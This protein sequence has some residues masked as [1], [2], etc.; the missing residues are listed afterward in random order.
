MHGNDLLTRRSLLL[1]AA[2]AGLTACSDS[3]SGA[4]SSATSAPPTSSAPTTAEPVDCAPPAAGPRAPLWQTALSRGLV[5]GSSAATWQIS[6]AEYRKLFQREAAILFTEDDLLWYRLRPSPGADL[7]FSFADQIIDFAE[8]NRMLVFGAHLTWDEGYG[9]GWTEADLYGMD[10][11]TASDLLFDTITQ[12]V[13]RYRGRVAAWSAVNEVVDGVGIRTDLAWHQTIGESYIADT[14]HVA[15]EADPDTM[16]LYNDFGYELDEDFALAAD[17][18]QVT[19][20]LLDD[21]LAKDVPVHALGVQAHLHAAQFA[22][23][24]DADAYRRFL[25]DVADRGLKILVT[26]LDVLDDDL[27][28]AAGPR[29]A[30]VAAAYRRYLEVTLDEPA[31]ISVMTFGLSD[32]YTWLQ[33]DTPRDDG[34]PRRPLPYG[35]DMRPKPAARALRAALAAAPERPVPWEMPPGRCA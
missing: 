2:A 16:L 15:N 26:E 30:A 12:T 13:R 5:Y 18:R 14:F 34:A 20:D 6:D 21:L 32:R 29:D 4:T 8:R 19:L 17:K 25:A 9:E 35:E 1:A 27:P 10:A 28:A 7:D 24:F 11:R 33:E 31:V 23:R 3:G 22:E